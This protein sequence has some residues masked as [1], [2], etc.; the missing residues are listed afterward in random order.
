MGTH[1]AKPHLHPDIT[2][3]NL[4]LLITG[5]LLHLCNYAFAECVHSCAHR[6][7]VPV[8]FPDM[9]HIGVSDFFALSLGIQKVK[10]VLDGNRCLIV[11]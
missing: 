11:G 2:K 4:I 3:S 10:K 7:D 8:G 1:R 6:T 9:N 5:D